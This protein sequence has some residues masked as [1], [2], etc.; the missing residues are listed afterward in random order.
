MFAVANR[1]LTVAA[2]FLVGTVVMPAKLEAQE[3]I[4][5]TVHNLSA[6][7]PGRIRAQSEAQVCIFCHAPH[8]TGGMK[9]LWNRDLSIASYQIYQSTTLDAVPGQPTGSSKLCLSCHDGTIALGNVLSRADQIL[10]SGGD[11]MPAGLSHLGTDLSDDHPISF[12]YSSGLAASDGQLKS[13]TALPHEVR[14]DANGQLQCTSCHDAHHN[15]FGKFLTKPRQF[16]ELC[17]SC[18]DMAGWSASPH[19]LSNSAVNATPP[20]D[21]P[22]GS[23][24][25]NACRSCHRPH[26]AGGHQRLLIS[27]NEEDNCLSCHDGQIAHANIRTE[28]D[29]SSSHD[30][31]LY[32]GRHDPRELQA[33]TNPHVECADCHNPHMATAQLNT[34]TYIP[35]GAT[36]VGTPGVTIAGANIARA[37]Y[38]YE[39][40]F[41]CHSD[42]AVPV[43][44]RIQRQAQTE[45]L[46][47]KFSPGNPS[48]HPLVVSSPS[49]ETPSLVPGVARG[50]LVRCTDCHNNDAGTRAGGI[51]PDGPHG[52]NYAY[53]LER[54]YETLDNN[55]ESEFDYAICY[56][57]HLRSSILGDQ[58]FSEHRKHIVEE[59]TPCSACHDPHGVNGV[60]VGG[61]EHTHLINFNTTIVRPSPSNQR[62]EYHDTGRLSGNCTLICHG[63]NHV[64]FSYR[65]N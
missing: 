23:V 50:S 53:L 2:L 1:S 3:R 60:L 13:P 8:N 51:G 63:E 57:C 43:P 26:A 45:N 14:L 34:G 41:R 42:T 21:W 20:N 36:L 5:D 40:C 31:R 38:E 32:A 39:V 49:T 61:S 30:P 48:F 17:L 56:K 9:P 52:S 4:V 65:P 55:V 7:G 47:L 29:K 33:G 15:R 58:S 27:Q 28:L 24:A 16:G 64:N 62:L 35:I 11:F 6:S 59:R 54:N 44:Q 25:E 19:R 37:L 10:M 46:R 12:F 18:H 22:F